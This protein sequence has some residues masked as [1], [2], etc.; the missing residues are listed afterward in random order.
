MP[1]IAIRATQSRTLAVLDRTA[2]GAVL[3]LPLLLLHAH[4]VAEGAI[5]LADLCFLAR[6]AISRDWV[7]ARSPWLLIGWAW[8][9]WLVFCS[10]PIPGLHLGEGGTRSLTQAIVFVRF[11]IFVA[12]LEQVILRSAEARR[13]LYRLI[14]ASAAYIAIQVIFQFFTGFGFWGDPIADEG[15][16]SRGRSAAPAPALRLSAS[17]S[18]RSFPGLRLC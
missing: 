12:A 3:V 14:A 11:F 13:W 18:R 7:W 8:W 2:L 16:F 5:A 4:G 10:L 17:C 1:E 15:V 9:G 6:S